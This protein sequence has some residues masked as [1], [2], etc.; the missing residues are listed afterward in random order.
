MPRVRS[1]ETK[2]HRVELG[3]WEREQVESLLAVGKISMFT[4]GVGIG[5]GVLVTGMSAWYTG[6][7]LYGWGQELKE[8]I[9]NAVDKATGGLGAEVLF[10][11]GT[12]VGPDGTEINNPLAGIPLLGSLFGSGI[13]IGQTFN[14]FD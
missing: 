13:M 10:G 3:V 1:D 11:R 2:T 9:D 4:K 8:D 7:K 5:I 12:Y 6:K 14:P